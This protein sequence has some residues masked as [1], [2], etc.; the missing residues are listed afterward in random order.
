MSWRHY[1]SSLFT[2]ITVVVAIQVAVG[3]SRENIIALP[4]SFEPV[5]SQ[6]STGA[7][8]VSRGPNTTLWVA[9]NGV[10]V[11]LRQQSRVVQMTLVGGN[12]RAEIDALEKTEGV[13]NYLVGADKTF[14][15]TNIPNYRSIAVRDIYPG[16]DI[17]YYGNEQHLEYDF[18][19]RPTADASRIRIRFDGIDGLRKDTDGELVLNAGSA[20]IRQ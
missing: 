17:L 7:R 13:S 3:A 19:V 10:A 5:P 20:E 11:G 4:L 15:R 9:A 18:V 2:V 14:W 6:P 8:Y 16:V 1:T 12:S